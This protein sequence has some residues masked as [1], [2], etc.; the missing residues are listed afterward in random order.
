M[1]MCRLQ[2]KKLKSSRKKTI[3]GHLFMKQS[4]NISKIG[5]YFLIHQLIRFYMPCIASFQFDNIPICPINS[6]FI[7]WCSILLP[8]FFNDTLT[9]NK[10]YLLIKFKHRF[11]KV[12]KLKANST[13][14][15]FQYWYNKTYCQSCVFLNVLIST[16][17][18]NSKTDFLF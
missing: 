12:T 5:Q 14:W 4:F 17:W 3:Q 18:K 7:P 2:I 15:C 1:D 11:E 9:W 8:A 6:I 16:D 13:Q 10:L